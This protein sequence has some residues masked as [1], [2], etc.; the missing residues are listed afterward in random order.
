MGRRGVVCDRYYFLQAPLRMLENGMSAAEV[1]ASS[2]TP[3][4]R[5]PLNRTVTSQRT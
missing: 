5:Q 1:S 2:G 4:S 3:P